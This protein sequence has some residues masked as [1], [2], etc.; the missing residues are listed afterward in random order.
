MMNKNDWAIF[1]TLTIGLPAIMVV[2]ALGV[3]EA[4]I[5]DPA[6]K[7]AQ[8][9]LGLISFLMVGAASWRQVQ[10]D[11]RSAGNGSDLIRRLTQFAGGMLAVTLSIA[12]WLLPFLL[13]VVLW[14][15]GILATDGRFRSILLHGAAFSA[16]MVIVY[17]MLRLISFGITQPFR[18]S[19]RADESGIT[20]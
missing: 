18:R 7:A 19:C 15:L 10:T 20:K 12:L 5:D 4:S 1:A 6:R 9:R 2:S 16:G 17:G 13:M 8:M 11:T 3:S 14:D